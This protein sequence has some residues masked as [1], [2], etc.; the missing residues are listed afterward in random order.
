MK[1]LYLITG[2]AGHL[3]VAT[4]KRLRSQDCVIRGLILPVEFGRND[5]K[6]TY[7][8]GDVTRPE[9]MDK[10]FSHSEAYEVIVIHMAAL[11]TVQE[12][13]SPVVYDVNVNGTRNVI[14]KCRQYHVKRLIYV[15]SV[16]AIPEPDRKVVLTEVS[17]FSKE[18]V[19]GEYAQTKAM[20]TQMVLDA[21]K[22]GLDVVVVHPSAMLGPGDPGR[23]H[24]IQ[25]MQMYL[26][27]KLPVCVQGGYDMVDV[28]DVAEGILSAADR[29]RSGECYLLTNRYVTMPELLEYMRRAARRKNR[30]PCFPYW[31]AKAALPLVKNIAG[32]TGRRLIFT[33]YSLQILRSGVHFCHD[34]A[35]MEL[36]YYPRDIR[37]TVTDTVQYLQ[38]L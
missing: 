16:H 21:G 34:K 24:L 20:A 10:F 23:N 22:K 15:S 4:I 29:G 38:R 35:S 30:T 8:T 37:D 28:R 36:F 5:D 19:Q 14:E 33:M 9:T 17:H 25:F 27:R 6:I 7:Y 13:I 31:L 26:D 1:R 32:R 18:E 11:I 12:K 2:A 3:A